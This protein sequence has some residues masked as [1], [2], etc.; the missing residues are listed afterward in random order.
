MFVLM[1]LRAYAMREELEYTPTSPSRITSITWI[2]SDTE[3]GGGNG[4]VEPK[5]A[6]GD[7]ESG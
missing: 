4:G 5:P 6:G 3:S 7:A 1:A 2:V